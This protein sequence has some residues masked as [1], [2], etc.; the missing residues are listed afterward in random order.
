M[1]VIRHSNSANTF[2]AHNSIIDYSTPRID[3]SLIGASKW[4]EDARMLVSLHST[5]DDTV[6]IVG[7]RGTGK[8][9]IARL[10]HRNSARRRGP[11]VSLSLGSITEDVVRSILFGSNENETADG[12]TQEK[13]LLQQAEGGTLYISGISAVSRTLV[14]EILRRS[15]NNRERAVRILFGWCVRTITDRYEPDETSYKDLDCE[16]IEIPPLRRRKDDIETLADYFIKQYCEQSGREP[17]KISPEAMDALCNYDWPRNVTE[18]KTLASQMVKQLDAPAIDVR[19]LP[20]YLAGTA[21]TINTLPSAGLDLD[22]EVKRVEVDLICAALRQS[23]GLQNRAAQ[24]LRIK[25]TTLFMKIKRYGID[26]G[27]FR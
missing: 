22:D 18:L 2:F 12:G 5:H 1:Q 21:R 4:T 15:L 6:T 8:R 26:V 14:D 9:L 16:R 19:N 10:I 11:F 17:R 3:E 7:E 25:P 27:V 20:T 13:G 24:L 23:H